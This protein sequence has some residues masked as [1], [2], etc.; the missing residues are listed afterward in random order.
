[1]PAGAVRRR[2][3]PPAAEVRRRGEEG[4]HLG[5]VGEIHTG[6]EEDAVVGEREVGGLLVGQGGDGDAG[7]ALE[8]APGDGSPQSAGAAGDD[9]SEALEGHG[10]GHGLLL[11]GRGWRA[12]HGN[13]TRA[14]GPGA[15]FLGL[16]L[17]YSSMGIYSSAWSARP[18]P[19]T[20]SPP[21]PSRGGARCWGPW[22]REGGSR[23]WAIW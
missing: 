17:T 4:V 12:G 23:R 20:P 2:P 8:Q 10:G 21:W 3:D 9:G 6:A 13:A 18:P 7:A 11:R 22:R 15:T 1:E 16:G 5:L 19:S 14:G